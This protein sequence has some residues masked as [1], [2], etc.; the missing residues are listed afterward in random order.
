MGSALGLGDWP[1]TQPLKWTS[2]LSYVTVM[3]SM[4]V[5][6][7]RSR[8]VQCLVVLSQLCVFGLTGCQGLL[9][10][11]GTSQVVLAD[12]LARTVGD[13]MAGIDEAGGST[14]ELAMR[15]PRSTKSQQDLRALTSSVLPEAQAAT[16][17][18]QGYS[19]CTANF[20]QRN[21]GGCTLAGVYL[22]TGTVDLTWAGAATNCALTGT[23]GSIRRSPNFTLVGGAGG[24]LSVSK[25][26]SF[27]QVLTW[28]SGSGTSKVFNYEND[29]IR[30]VITSGGR[31]VADLTTTTTSAITVT[32]TGRSGRSL[33]GG[34]LRVTNNLTGETCTMT[35]QNVQ[36]SAGCTCASSGTWSGSCSSTGS[37]TLSITSCGG[38]VVTYNG[39][40][41]SVSLDRCV[42][43]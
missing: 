13:A 9:Q 11:S 12:E 21:F 34:S 22:L 15:T 1:Q 43:S 42:G 6:V 29:G 14:G 27:G 16:C 32:G 10:D 24:T 31:S 40:N 7:H 2:W 18:G 36:W 23:G 20:M 3:T 37:F 17:Y 30:R 38:G 19:A 5:A 8:F 28:V 26:G 33:S 35:P 25:S 41:R 39:Q 4:S